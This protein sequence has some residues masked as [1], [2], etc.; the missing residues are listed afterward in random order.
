M[1]ERE[2]GDQILS[3]TVTAPL[4]RFLRWS[5]L[6][7]QSYCGNKI[8]RLWDRI[9]GGKACYIIAASGIQV[10]LDIRDIEL[11]TYN[12]IMHKYIFEMA[13]EYPSVGWLSSEGILLGPADRSP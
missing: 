6:A 3:V 11:S 10:T 1:R 2:G 7:L 13:L 4:F 8:C 12:E 9:S 5:L